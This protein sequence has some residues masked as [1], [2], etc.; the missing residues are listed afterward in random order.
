LIAT[1]STEIV[2]EAETDE[3]VVVDKRRRRTARIRNPGQLE[4]VFRAL[5]SSVNP[6]LTQ[7]AKTRRVIF[8]E[9]TDFQLL[10]RF[11]RKLGFD[12][13]GNRS[14]FA[15][16]TV[17][18]FNPERIRSLKAGMEATLGTSVAAAAILDR[19]Y[20]SAEECR[21]IV[22]TCETFC[23]LVVIHD[24]KEIENFL[25]VPDAIDRAAA[26]RLAD[27]AKRSTTE[28]SVK[29]EPLALET[30]LEFAN[31]QRHYVASQYVTSRQRYERS[32]GSK[33]FVETLTEGELADFERRWTDGN[34]IFG[35]IPGK[36]A[37]SY[38]NQRLRDRFDVNVTPTSIVEAMR[39]TE[40][41]NEVA[42]LIN[43]L[44]NFSKI[45]IS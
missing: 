28:V 3:I 45:S 14:D 8:V 41:Q 11:A 42:V 20:R 44:D 10:G 24:S 12:R 4:S 21:Q 7:L 32:I 9:G 23:D 5:G 2:T 38:V 30:L 22:A 37:L 36:D 43:R 15:V 17:D 1:H 18:G 34:G 26:S 35:I 40:V 31:A 19:D 33:T 29:F 16:V 25:L 13:V 39:V 27:R 6:I